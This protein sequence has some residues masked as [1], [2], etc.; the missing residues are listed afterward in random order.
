[1]ILALPKELHT[2][3]FI[4]VG[5]ETSSESGSILPEWFQN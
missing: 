2:A 1:M 5:E 4:L 3:P